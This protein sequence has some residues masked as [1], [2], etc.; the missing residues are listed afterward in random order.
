MTLM[1]GVPPSRLRPSQRSEQLRN[2]MPWRRALKKKAPVEDATEGR[3][4]IKQWKLYQPPV[5][6]NYVE[7]DYVP[8][9]ASTVDV[10][11]KEHG[12]S[13]WVEGNE[14]PLRPSNNVLQFRPENDD[15]LQRKLV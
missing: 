2:P 9:L 11:F 12:K 4:I 10:L 15:E 5:T 7:P 3:P 1:P 13:L 8:G 6:N 14:L